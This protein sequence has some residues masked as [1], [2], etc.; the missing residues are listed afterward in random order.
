MWNFFFFFK[1]NLP[2]QL[3]DAFIVICQTGLLKQLGCIL[4]LHLIEIDILTMPIWMP[5]AFLVLNE[6]WFLL[7]YQDVS[8]PCSV[9][10]L[11]ACNCTCE[12]L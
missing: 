10:I 3:L 5:N 8:V 4:D 7:F 12:I 1:H 11:F 9:T 6:L 2:V